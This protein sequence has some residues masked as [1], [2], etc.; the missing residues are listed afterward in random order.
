VTG[1]FRRLVARGNAKPMVATAIARDLQREHTT[2]G[3]TGRTGTGIRP[4]TRLA[5]EAVDQR[6][7]PSARLT[8]MARS[9][10]AP[11]RG[12]ICDCIRSHSSSRFS[13]LVERR[14]ESIYG[15]LERF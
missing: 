14:E 15:M 5:L 8:L 12:R 11:R 10:D 1:R 7:A 6:L 4:I 2:H 3:M 13:V 9:H